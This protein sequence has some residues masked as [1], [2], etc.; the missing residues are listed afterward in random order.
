MAHYAELR[1]LDVYVDVLVL[2]I[3]C[4]RAA[5]NLAIG[6]EDTV[7]D[8]GQDA[9]LKIQAIAKRKILR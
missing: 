7:A 5:I 8:W 2:Q 6:S 4:V 3:N 9:I 1:L